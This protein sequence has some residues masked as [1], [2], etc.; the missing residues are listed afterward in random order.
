[1]IV[2]L[3]LVQNLKYE[4]QVIPNP[5]LGTLGKTSKLKIDKRNPHTCLSAK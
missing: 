1:M 4:N 3:F 2:N 5:T